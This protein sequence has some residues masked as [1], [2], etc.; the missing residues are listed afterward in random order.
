MCFINYAGSPTNNETLR[1]PET[2]SFIIKYLAKKGNFF[3]EN[4]KYKETDSIKSVQ[5]SLKSHPI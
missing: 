3:S 5:S 1:G 2:L 4:L